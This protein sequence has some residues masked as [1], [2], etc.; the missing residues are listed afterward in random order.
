MIK[1][2]H[3]IHYFNIFIVQLIKIYYIFVYF[4]I[5]HIDTN[6]ESYITENPKISHSDSLE[7]SGFKRFKI[8]HEAL[9]IEKRSIP[10][11]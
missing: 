7:L 8:K 6:I 11:I 3:L 9:F 5:N 1:K 10:K 4:S 2:V